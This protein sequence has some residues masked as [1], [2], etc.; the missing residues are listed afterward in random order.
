MRCQPTT[1][2]FGCGTLGGIVNYVSLSGPMTPLAQLYQAVLWLLIGAMV[3][4]A[5][6]SFI[7][8]WLGPVSRR[9]RV[10]QRIAAGALIL[11]SVCALAG[12]VSLVLLQ[13]SAWCQS[14]AGTLYS[15][16]SGAAPAPTSSFWGGYSYASPLGPVEVSWGPAPG[17]YI[18]IMAGVLFLAVALTAFHKSGGLR[19]V[20]ARKSPPV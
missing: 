1:T 6:A 17:W 10:W 19:A 3:A 2:P 15:C 13:T 7:L 14:L 16:G 18:S 8:L 4:G 9:R 20:F 5:I 11:A 12:P